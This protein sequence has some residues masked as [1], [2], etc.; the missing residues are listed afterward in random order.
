[1]IGQQGEDAAAR[2]VQ[3]LG[4]RIIARNWRKGHLEIDIICQDGDTIVFVE[5]KTRKSTGMQAP[6]EAL[7][8]H[9]QRTLIRASHA[10]LSANNAWHIPCRF[11]F[12]GVQYHGTTFTT[13]HMPHAFDLTSAL[14]SRHTT[15]QP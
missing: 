8:L 2:L 6:H 14:G 7:T 15:W 12:I 9:K 11:D 13:E 1:M 3:S 10:W 4:M 5:V